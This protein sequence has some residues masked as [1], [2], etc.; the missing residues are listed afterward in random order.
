MKKLITTISALIIA[1]SLNINKVYA[2]PPPAPESCSDG[3]VLMD[4]NTGQILYSKNM[5]AAY[6]P[7]STTKVMTILLTLERCKLDAEVTVGKNPPQI[8]YAAR[9]SS[10]SLVEGEKVTVKD[11]LY[12]LILRSGN[13]CAETLA[14]YIGGTSSNFAAIMNA[15]AKE[16]GCTNT[17]FVNPSGLYDKN[18]KTS[19]KDLAIIMSELSKHPEFKTI[20]TTTYYVIPPNNKF[21]SGHPMSNENKIVNYKK[22]S[23][24]GYEGS[25]TGWTSESLY[26]FTAVASRNGQKL[27]ISLVHGKES[28]FYTDAKNYLDWGFSNFE[29]V[30]VY[31]KGDKVIDY[32]LEDNK[33]MPLLASED[34]FFTREKGSSDL[35]KFSYDDENLATKSFKANEAVLTLKFHINDTTLKPLVLKSEQEHTYKPSPLAVLSTKSNSL[36]KIVKYILLSIFSALVLFVVFALIRKKHRAKKRQVKNYKDYYMYK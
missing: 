7:A 35:P 36:G 25:K 30:K 8:A 23:I 4:A 32:K 18:H 12:G 11:L 13:D 31:S 22:Y 9:S 19:A 24:D 21:A 10:I 2:A 26:S 28:A 27:V 33:T 5:D 16:L 6:P 1:F 34:Y 29:A 20:S 17:N 14:E 15:R 3:V